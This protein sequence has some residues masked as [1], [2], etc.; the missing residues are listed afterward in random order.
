LLT[1][2]S[3]LAHTSFLKGEARPK[4]ISFNLRRGSQ[5]QIPRT[6]QK[7]KQCPKVYSLMHCDDPSITYDIPCN[8]DTCLWDTSFLDPLQPPSV[9]D[10]ITIAD[11]NAADIPVAIRPCAIWSIMFGEHQ[12]MSPTSSGT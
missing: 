10:V 1:L 11:P 12:S 4:I 8:W 5:Q 6:L 7:N 9:C 3:A 2:N